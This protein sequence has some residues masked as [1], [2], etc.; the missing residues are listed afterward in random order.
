MFRKSQNTEKIQW[1]IYLKFMRN[2]QFSL[3]KISNP[4]PVAT[5]RRPALYK[6]IMT[7]IYLPHTGKFS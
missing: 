4:L 1:N 7:D 3:I 2:T 5:N 6:A